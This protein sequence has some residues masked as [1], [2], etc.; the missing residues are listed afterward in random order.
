MDCKQY[1]NSME[2]KINPRAKIVP[3]GDFDM[4][5]I[6]YN[7]QG[8]IVTETQ[9]EKYIRE[10]ANQCTVNDFVDRP[11]FKCQNTCENPLNLNYIKDKIMK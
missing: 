11:R 10:F 7:T 5:K 3:Y 1:D 2:F 6:V 9:R 8:Q 4:K